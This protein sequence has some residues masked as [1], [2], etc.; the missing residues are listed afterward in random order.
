MPDKTKDTRLSRGPN[1]HIDIRILQ[2]MASGIPL[3]LGNR[4]RIQDPSVH[5][6]SG[7]L[8]RGQLNIIGCRPR[9]LLERLHADLSAISRTAASI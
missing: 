2:T 9:A 1:D 6:V 5:V 8:A 7:A 3:V 4:T